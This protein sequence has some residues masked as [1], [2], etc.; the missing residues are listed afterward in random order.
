[1]HCFIQG[2][3]DSLLRIRTLA[4]SS[5]QFSPTVTSSQNSVQI[6][7][8]VVKHANPVTLLMAAHF[9]AYIVTSHTYSELINSICR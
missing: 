8:L 1:M 9:Y 2:E 4:L 6:V 3:A 7:V 5:T